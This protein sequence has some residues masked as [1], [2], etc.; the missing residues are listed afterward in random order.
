MEKS[1]KRINVVVKGLLVRGDSFL[2]V[3]RSDY[4]LS[5]VGE[6]ELPG[7]RLEFGESP[8]NALKREFTE[9]TGLKIDVVKTLYT[10][11]VI[12]NNVNQI[13]GITFLCKVPEDAVP[14][15]SREHTEYAWINKDDFC[16]WEL[17]ADIKEDLK[18]LNW[19]L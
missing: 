13:V 7:G 1:E 11:T 12:R 9:E 5:R 3:K 8:E 15:L 17:N 14:V 10:W 2:A 16:N 4:S 19:C 18:K 6:W